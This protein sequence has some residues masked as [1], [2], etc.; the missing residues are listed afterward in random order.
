[1]YLKISS[2]IT[3]WFYFFNKHDFVRSYCINSYNN[4]FRILILISVKFDILSYMNYYIFYSDLVVS[5]LADI[6]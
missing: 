1:M 5:L 6:L 4:E 2:N 3:E